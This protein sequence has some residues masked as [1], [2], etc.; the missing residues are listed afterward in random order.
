MDYLFGFGGRINRAKMWLF[1]LVTLAWEIVIGLIA[2]LGLSWTRFLHEFNG[3]KHAGSEVVA[4]FP[5]PDPISGTGWIA[6]G[7]IAMLALL[8]VIALFA[9]YT[10]RLHDRNKGAWWVVLFLVIPWGVSLLDYLPWQ[11]LLNLG[12]HFGP[13]GVGLD[14]AR[15]IAAVL[16]IWALIELFFFRGTP[17]EN[18]YGPDPLAK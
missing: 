7:V 10:K 1:I 2:A 15:F 8:Y 9:V 16:G 3:M 12:E 14:T 4:A 6:A 13:L 5:C 11:N 17:G 18:R